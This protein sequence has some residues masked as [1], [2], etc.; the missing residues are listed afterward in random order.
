MPPAPPPVLV[1]DGDAVARQALVGALADAGHPAQGCATTRAAL[2]LAARSAL[3][4]VV[5]E[6]EQPGLSGLELCRSLR[7]S[8]GH[9]DVPILVL[10]ARAE[11]IDRVVAFEVGVDDFAAKP[12][13]VREVVLRVRALLRRAR[14]LET[15]RVA[16]GI[17]VDVDAHRVFAG[18]QPVD[19]GVTEF[20]VLAALAARGGRVVPRAALLEE[21]WELHA[22]EDGR[23]LD[24][25]IKRL[26]ARLGPWGDLVQTVRGVGYRLV[27][28]GF[29]GPDRGGRR[30]KRPD[31]DAQP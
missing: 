6:L 22:S 17:R 7:A 8:V 10:S 4:A 19:V 23:R 30:H 12:F 25:S 24:Q 15:A 26:R 14:R 11:E 13:S 2:A 27:A 9:A 21:I 18:G 5:T 3:A 20:R 31:A 29:P 1:A 16:E 28:D